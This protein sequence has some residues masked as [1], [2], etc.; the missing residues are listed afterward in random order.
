MYSKCW[1]HEGGNLYVN[2]VPKRDTYFRLLQIKVHPCL[3][4]ITIEKVGLGLA[5]ELAVEE[6]GGS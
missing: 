5:T 6:N 2:I 3:S 1:L 4:Q